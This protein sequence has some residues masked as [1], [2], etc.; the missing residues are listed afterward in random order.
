[1]NSIFDTESKIIHF[2]GSN[3]YI[4]TKIK[5]WP[6]FKQDPTKGSYWTKNSPVEQQLCVHNHIHDGRLDVVE[7]VG[8]GLVVRRVGGDEELE[9]GFREVA[10]LLEEKVEQN[11]WREGKE[12][13]I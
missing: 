3:K 4:I 1:M 6:V 2:M 10:A 8:L 7:L 9:E 13:F 12:I 5:C 11:L